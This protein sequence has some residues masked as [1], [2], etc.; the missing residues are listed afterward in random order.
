MA[1]LNTNYISFILFT[2]LI[3]RVSKTNPVNYLRQI[4]LKQTT[5]LKLM[6]HE[7][8]REEDF[9]E[10]QTETEIFVFALFFSCFLFV[11][12]L[13]V[14]FCFVLFCCVVFCSVFFSFHVLVQ[15]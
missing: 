12:L 2:S 15:E 4:Y 3:I 9:C 5:T 10:L 1:I 8:S 13:F 14:C 11:L 7:I 6:R